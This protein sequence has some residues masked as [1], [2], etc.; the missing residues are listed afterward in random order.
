MLSTE[1]YDKK[2]FL[3][4]FPLLFANYPHQLRQNIPMKSCRLISRQWHPG[5]SGSVPLTRQF[6]GEMRQV[7]DK[8]RERNLLHENASEKGGGRT[9]QYGV[10]TE[11]KW[12]MSPAFSGLVTKGWTLA[13]SVSVTLKVSKTNGTIVRAAEGLTAQSETGGGAMFIMLP[14]S[15]VS[16]PSLFTDSLVF[17]GNRQLKQWYQLVFCSDGWKW[18]GLNEFLYLSPAYTPY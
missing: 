4:Y 7:G 15:L 18:R 8:C 12:C 10:K 17:W 11:G 16:L 6:Q 13:F 2:L 9:R 1:F 5:I 14:G 3:I